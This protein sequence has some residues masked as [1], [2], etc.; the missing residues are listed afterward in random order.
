MKKIICIMA[1]AVVIAPS[2][3][4]VGQVADV[5][6]SSPYHQTATVPAV[7]GYDFG[8]TLPNGGVD[9]SF[10]QDTLQT[11][12]QQYFD[13]YHVSGKNVKSAT[14][15][16][17]EVTM[18]TATSVDFMDKIEIYVSADGLPEVLVAYQDNI[19]KGQRTM[20]LLSSGQNMREYI[21]HPVVYGRVKAHLNKIP[22]P[23]TIL[24]ISA[25]FEMIANAIVNYDK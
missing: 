7:P 13:Q 17:G 22:A 12:S 9:V 3:R 18:V 19:P 5:S 6:F 16:T 20:T 25:E 8:S 21:K 4:K 2:C 10:P 11:N 1:M 14:F 23:G 15:S 24:N